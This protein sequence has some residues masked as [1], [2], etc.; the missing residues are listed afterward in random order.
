MGWSCLVFGM[1]MDK[2][3]EAGREWI[4]GTWWVP[5]G[6]SGGG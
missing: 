4:F 2:E 1:G 6:D 5:L 3:W